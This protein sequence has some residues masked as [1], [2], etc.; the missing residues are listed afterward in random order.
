VWPEHLVSLTR[1]TAS[2]FS[3]PA[4]RARRSAVTVQSKSDRVVAPAHLLDK[5]T[6]AR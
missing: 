2:G 4:S 1:N 5:H 3:A 6:D